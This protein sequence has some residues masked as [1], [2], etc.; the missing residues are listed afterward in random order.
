MT[1]DMIFSK[2]TI[3]KLLSRFENVLHVTSKD[4]DTFGSSYDPGL[5]PAAYDHLILLDPAT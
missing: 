4:P 1:F 5:N 3:Q 2:K